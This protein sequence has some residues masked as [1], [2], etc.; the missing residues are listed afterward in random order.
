L[1]FLL[2]A[3]VIDAF[4][5][6]LSWFI[7]PRVYRLDKSGG[8]RSLIFFRKQI[9]AR[10]FGGKMAIDKQPTKNVQAD[11]MKKLVLVMAG[12]GASL[13]P[14]FQAQNPTY[15]SDGRYLGFQSGG[16]WYNF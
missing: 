14:S 3:E 5:N 11:A 13:L 10:T 12:L 2:W 16:F 7:F 8:L 1:L 4:T 9:G 15:D 6:A